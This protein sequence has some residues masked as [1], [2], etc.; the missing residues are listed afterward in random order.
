[1]DTIIRYGNGISRKKID[2]NTG[3]GLKFDGVNDY[4]TFGNILSHNLTTTFSF[5][6]D[7]K[8]KVNNNLN[9]IISKISATG[10][11]YYVSLQENSNNEIFLALAINQGNRYRYKIVLPNQL[12]T[13][14]FIVVTKNNTVDSDA[15][16]F[17]INGVKYPA[18]LVIQ[19]A[20]P[21]SITNT[22]GWQIGTVRSGGFA[23][24]MVCN[25]IG[26]YNRQL[27]DAEAEQLYVNQSQTIPSTCIANCTN[28]WTFENKQGAI[29]SDKKSTNN[30][31]LINFADT[32]LGANNAW[33]DKYE[34]SIT[35]L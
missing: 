35:A 18:E 17:Y 6:I 13:R 22:S 21:T 7:V 28:F 3:D 19:G 30:G 34:N 2:W 24:G 16:N 20:L 23:T 4:V 11:G 31:S 12:N 25:Y 14:L 5:V 26:A 9:Y 10:L 29:L 27:T 33:V 15:V 32:T 1:M 8:L